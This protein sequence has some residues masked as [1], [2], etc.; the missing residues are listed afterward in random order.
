MDIPDLTVP[1]IGDTGSTPP[2]PAHI[3]H[4]PPP[5]RSSSPPLPPRK[6]ALGLPPTYTAHLR[7][8]LHQWLTQQTTNADLPPTADHSNTPAPLWD[9]HKVQAIEKAI[10]TG[11]II[12]GDKA[13][14]RKRLLQLDW[15]DWTSGAA[16]RKRLWRDTHP[17]SPADSMDKPANETL[18][19]K[20][21]PQSIHTEDGSRG[22]LAAPP[23]GL[24]TLSTSSTPQRIPSR[25]PSVAS[26]ERT[27]R[28]DGTRSPLGVSPSIN[29]GD[30]QDPEERQRDFHH[31]LMDLRGFQPFTVQSK[32]E[33]E[34]LGGTYRRSVL[35]QHAH[36][37]TTFPRHIRVNARYRALFRRVGTF[38]MLHQCPR[39]RRC[40]RNIRLLACIS[41]LMILSS[42]Y[43][44]CISRPRLQVQVPAR[45][46]F[47]GSRHWD[48]APIQIASAQ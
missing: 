15:A 3:P 18:K 14:G 16:R 44:A 30:G 17:H 13:D 22:T 1:D 24:S 2:L 27:W 32:D 25:P 21:R 4:D 42:R 11:A 6:H 8:L 9:D 20:R 5:L 45:Y 28:G 7:A 29:E 10:W 39:L 48:M 33:W 23:T 41:Q 46:I 47:V 37:Q 36:P 40:P 12:P 19:G 35:R 38:A 43:S 34:V 31:V 26:T